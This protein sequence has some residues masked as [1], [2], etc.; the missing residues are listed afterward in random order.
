MIGVLSRP[1]PM[2]GTLNAVVKDKI[3]DLQKQDFCDCHMHLSFW[4]FYLS[5]IP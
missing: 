1:C 3:V 2:V 4:V 5:I